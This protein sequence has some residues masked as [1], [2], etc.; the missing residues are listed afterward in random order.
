MGEDILAEDILV[1]GRAIHVLLVLGEGGAV[2]ER[3]VRIEQSTAL[4]VSL[5]VQGTRAAARTTVSREVVLLGGSDTP[6]RVPKADPEMVLPLLRDVPG[7]EPEWYD[8]SG[9]GGEGGGP[10]DH[11]G[12]T[13]APSHVDY[14]ELPLSPP[15][16]NPS[17]GRVRMFYASSRFRWLTSGG[18]LHRLLAARDF[19]AKGELLVG[20]GDDTFDELPVGS[21]G[22][23][24]TADS[25][26][27]M[28]MR[29]ATPEEGGA[30]PGLAAHDS[31]GLATDAELATHAGAAD[32]HPVYVKG[33]VLFDAEA[34]R[35]VGKG[36]GTL[37]GTS[38]TAAKRDHRHGYPYT[39]F[40]VETDTTQ[41]LAT[42]GSAAG[43]TFAAGN[44]VIDEG[45]MCDA[46]NNRFLMGPGLWA[47]E[48]FISWAG[49]ATGGREFTLYRDSPSVG[50]RAMMTP[51]RAVVFAQ[52][53]SF[54]AYI[55]IG[56]SEIWTL[57]ARQA[58]G[59]SLNIVLKS[60]AAHLIRPA[61]I[62][63]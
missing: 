2:V 33:S 1:E 21:D 10:H 35:D 46:P 11:L 3:D 56:S 42:S 15:P 39:G 48:F 24:L 55:P 54:T 28:G 60:F 9:L 31:L 25:A 62:T 61:W 30:H 34:P 40:L 5:G 29:W 51:S 57:D 13:L 6:S 52:P 12:D 45:S 49:N 22:Q 44:I 8:A 18:V 38:S 20:T 23:V 43:V 36:L 53:I 7:G 37:V 27:A 41:T 4:R 47:V 14:A 58:S 16:S 63:P 59:G 50:F 26:Q 19:D 17:A 32:P